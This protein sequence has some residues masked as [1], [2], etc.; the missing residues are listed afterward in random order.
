MCSSDLG[1]TGIA[2]NVIQPGFVLTEPGARIREI[3][4]SMP[5]QDQDAMLA[6][7]T[8]RTPEE[9]GY[10]VTWLAAQGEKD[11]TGHAVRLVGKI[12]TLDLALTRDP[13]NPLANTARLARKS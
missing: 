7:R 6:R 12:D 13:E 1:G 9:L 10:A 11:L 8:P 3:F 4:D 5:K 2:V